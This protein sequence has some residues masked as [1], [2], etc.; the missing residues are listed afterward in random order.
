[1]A[2]L[3]SDAQIVVSNYDNIQWLA[4]QALDFDAIVFDELTRL[5]NPAAHV[6]KR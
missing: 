2:A 4:E 5:K 6:S 3:R 1:M